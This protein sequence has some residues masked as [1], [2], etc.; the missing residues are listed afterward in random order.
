MSDEL[1]HTLLALSRK[2]LTL[3]LRT[4]VMRDLVRHRA[5]LIQQYLRRQGSREPWGEALSQADTPRRRAI[6]EL[7]T[8]DP[9]HRRLVQVKAELDAILATQT[10]AACTTPL[11]SSELH[12]TAVRMVTR[13]RAFATRQLEASADEYSRELWAEQQDYYQEFEA[14]LHH[15]WY[16][17]AVPP[18]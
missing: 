9:A 16:D 1:A 6:G 13:R 17:A 5:H 14:I 8:H 12:Q 18:R 7:L 11:L 4:L 15:Q 3:F 2:Q 10:Y